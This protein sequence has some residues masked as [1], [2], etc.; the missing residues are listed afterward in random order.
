MSSDLTELIQAL[1]HNGFARD[2]VT[3]DYV[4]G[5]TMQDGQYSAGAW[6]AAERLGKFLPMYGQWTIAQI[7]EAAQKKT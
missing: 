1:E 4:I 2:N 7:K 5:N 3:L 6:Q